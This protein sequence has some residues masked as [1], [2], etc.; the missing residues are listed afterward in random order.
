M[1]AGIG[2]RAPH[3][4]RV[5]D[6]CPPV[7]WFEVHSENYFA[8]GGP[9]LLALERVRRDYP[10]SLHG[11]GMSLGSADEPDPTHLRKLKALVDRI[12][13]AACRTVFIAVADEDGALAPVA[14]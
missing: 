5:L 12:D 1:Q 3:L 13:P 14:A 10:L 4:R 6:E 2:L 11:V 8:A 9:A 7:A